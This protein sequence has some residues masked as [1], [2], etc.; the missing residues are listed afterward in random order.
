MF[1]EKKI[2]Y[3]PVTNCMPPFYPINYIGSVFS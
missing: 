1:Y 3:G 2:F